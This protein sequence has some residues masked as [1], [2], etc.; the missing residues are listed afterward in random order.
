MISHPMDSNYLEIDFKLK[1]VPLFLARKIDSSLF[2]SRGKKHWE[3]RC[4]AIL[5]IQAMGLKNV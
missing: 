4:E 2:V 3:E 5:E 1:E